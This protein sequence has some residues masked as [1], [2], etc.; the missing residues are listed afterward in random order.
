MKVE[1]RIE[2][3]VRQCQKQDVLDAGCVGMAIP[4]NYPEWLH[5][6]IRKHAKFVLGIDSNLEKIKQLRKAGYNIKFADAENFSL[7]RKFDVIVASELIEHLSN[8]GLFLKCA[9][10]H[11]RRGGRLVLTT[12]NARFPGNWFFEQSQDHVCIF[13]MQLLRQLLQKNSFKI[14]S[15]CY[16]NWSASHSFL[17]GIYRR[18]F[19]HFFP[20]YADT[21]GMIAEPCKPR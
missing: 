15:A 12:P 9:R 6:L 14:I 19:L 13:T 20:I 10:S 21:I 17:G 16:L 5:G 1:N 11:L 2:W 3:I 7:S 18:I 8:P 4:Y